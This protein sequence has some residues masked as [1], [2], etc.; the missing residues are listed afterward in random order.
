MAVVGAFLSI[1]LLLLY[2]SAAHLTILW[3]T[4]TGVFAES[5]PHQSAATLCE[6]FLSGRHITGHRTAGRF[7]SL[8]SSEHTQ[9]YPNYVSAVLSTCHRSNPASAASCLLTP[10]ACKSLPVSCMQEDSC[11]VGF[12]WLY[13]LL[14]VNMPTPAV[15]RQ[16]LSLQVQ[17]SMV[18]Q[19]MQ[20][21][22]SIQC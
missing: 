18:S 8:N 21:F 22:W 2:Y 17:H 4:F 10:C 20:W 9:V 6:G 7:L 5:L 14:N 16:K 19:A 15:K 3:A 11:L 12:Y 13:L 1:G